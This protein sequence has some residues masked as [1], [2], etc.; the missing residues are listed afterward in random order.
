MHQYFDQTLKQLGITGKKLAEV[1]GVSTTHI[2]EFRNGKTNPSCE[3]LE[4]MLDGAD[5]ITPGAK[6]YFCELLAG[7]EPRPVEDPIELLDD[8]QLARLLLKV[9]N[10]LEKRKLGLSQELLSA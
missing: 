4:R 2:S 1:T 3:M 10:R 7:K 8:T 5:Q 6:R 9:A